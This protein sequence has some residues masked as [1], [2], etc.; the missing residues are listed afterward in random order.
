MSLYKVSIGLIVKGPPSQGYHP[1]FPY[2]IVT[3]GEVVKTPK[4][5]SPSNHGP[6]FRAKRC[7]QLPQKGPCL[8]PPTT[9]VCW[10]VFWIEHEIHSKH[11]DMK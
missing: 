6:T 8:Q 1:H 5:S 7:W 9:R 2:D 4:G 11:I 10:G 3:L